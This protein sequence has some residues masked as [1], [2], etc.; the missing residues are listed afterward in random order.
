MRT[1]AS[2]LTLYGLYA[3]R[4]W[5]AASDYVYHVSASDPL[6][7]NAI[8]L[9]PL[10]IRQPLGVS[11]S[12]F[13]RGQ[14]RDGSAVAQPMEWRYLESPEPGVPLVVKVYGA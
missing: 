12:Q 14:S 13:R 5:R 3:H 8:A 4:A 9:S 11:P 6:N 1:R 10:S 2:P 7:V